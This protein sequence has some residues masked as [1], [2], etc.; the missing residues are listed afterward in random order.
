MGTPNVTQTTSCDGAN[1]KFSIDLDASS[2]TSDI[3]TITVTHGPKTRTA[4]VP[5]K[6]APLSVSEADPFRTLT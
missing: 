1:N 5:N 2:I 4:N 3:A 6:M